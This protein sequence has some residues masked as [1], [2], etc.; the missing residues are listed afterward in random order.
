MR[1]RPR[2]PGIRAWHSAIALVSAACSLGSRRFRCNSEAGAIQAGNSGLRPFVQIADVGWAGRPAAAG[3]A[4]PGRKNLDA[5]RKREANV[6]FVRRAHLNL[7]GEFPLAA[8][9]L[10]AEQMAFSRMPPHYFPRR[11]HLEPLRG[12]AMRLQLHFLV[13]FHK[14]LFCR[15]FTLSAAQAALA[16]RRRLPFSARA[17]PTKYSPPCAARIPPARAR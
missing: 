6:V 7:A 11:R 1:G 8:R 2:P 16:P 4:L 5:V 10:G 14:S 9:R 12:P 15:E 3:Y 17:R 13:L